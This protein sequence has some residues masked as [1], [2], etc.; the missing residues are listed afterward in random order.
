MQTRTRESGSGRQDWSSPSPRGQWRTNGGNWL[1]NHLWCPNPS[2]LRDRWEMRDSSNA[3]QTWTSALQSATHVQR[4][5][6]QICPEITSRLG[7]VMSKMLPRI[8]VSDLITTN[9]RFLQW[10]CRRKWC[11]FYRSITIGCLQAALGYIIP[12][13][14]AISFFVS[15][16]RKK[17]GGKN[18]KQSWLPAF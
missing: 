1:R 8:S 13:T 12:S 10:S 9:F 14:I 5:W 4:G 17:G 3:L 15:S 2:R 11:S 18:L 16:F 7:L 6:A